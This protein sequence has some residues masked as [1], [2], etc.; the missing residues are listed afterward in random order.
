M[1]RL[2]QAR[3]EIVTLENECKEQTPHMSLDTDTARVRI[4][5]I[6]HSL[7]EYKL[8]EGRGRGGGG[9]QAPGVWWNPALFVAPTHTQ[10]LTPSA[11]ATGL[12]FH[13]SVRGSGHRHK[14]GVVLGCIY[15]SADTIRVGG[16]HRV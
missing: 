11:H 9:G 3:I 16:G 15:K 6:K 8:E 1:A 12:S 2:A 5:C 10:T 14:G 7:G 4:E 13:N